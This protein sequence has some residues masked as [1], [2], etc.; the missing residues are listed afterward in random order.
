MLSKRH[1]YLLLGGSS[2]LIVALIASAAAVSRR[3]DPVTVPEQTAIHVTLDQALASNQSRPGDH[4]EAT[5]AEPIMIDEK[6]II[7]EGAHAEGLVV[8]ARP[9]GRLR[10]R[11]R[12]QLALETVEINGMTYELRTNTAQRAGGNHKKRNWG[13]IAGGAGGG[14]LIGALAAGGKG[15]LI[16]GPVGAGAGTAVAFMTGKKDIHLSAEAPLTFRLVRPVTINA[17]S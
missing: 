2:V 9:S 4:F 16:G 13:W 12:L 3:A 6:T 7:P 5:V 8:D 10:G 17:K 11:A 15:A 14:A 1:Q